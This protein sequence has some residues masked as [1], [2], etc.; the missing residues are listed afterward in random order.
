MYAIASINLCCFEN[1]SYKNKTKNWI[2]GNVLL[3]IKACLQMAQLSFQKL[4]EINEKTMNI[5]QVSML[6][7]QLKSSCDNVTPNIID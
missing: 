3:R 7:N 1:S 4:Q 2:R 5:N 6:I